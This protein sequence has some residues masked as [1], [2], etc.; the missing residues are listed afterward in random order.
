MQPF[1]AQ[2]SPQTEERRS[3]TRGPWWTLLERY[4]EPKALGQ[5]PS[6]LVQSMRLFSCTSSDSRECAYARKSQDESSTTRVFR[7]GIRDDSSVARW[8]S[9]AKELAA[10]K[11]LCRIVWPP[12]QARLPGAMAR[13]RFQSQVTEPICSPSSL[14]AQAR[15]IFSPFWPCA[16]ALTRYRA[17]WG[18]PTA[19]SANQS[20]C[21]PTASI[22]R[23]YRRRHGHSGCALL[24]GGIGTMTTV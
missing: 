17:N 5:L 11:L 6:I 13:G 3:T 2:T 12:P 7:L 14:P 9:R 20:R 8:Y 19:R 16:L 24:A 18:R 4:H 21:R 1:V 22:L 23:N 10:P 15:P